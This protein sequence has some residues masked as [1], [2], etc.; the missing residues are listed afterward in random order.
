MELPS[1]FA[2]VRTEAATIWE[3]LESSPVL[4]GPWHRMFQ[5]VRSPRH[6]LSELL[7]NADDSGATCASAKIV[8]DTF[9]FEHN[10]RDF[11]ADEFA[12]LCRF[13]YSNKRALHT[14]GF[15]GVGF[16]STFS[17]GDEVHLST[18]TLSVKFTKSRF[19]EPVWTPEVP[20]RERTTIEVHLTDKGAK[21]ELEM[22]LAEWLASSASLLFFRNVRTLQVN[23]TELQWVDCGD[24]PCP[25]ST[26][27]KLNGTEQ[28]PCLL[29]RSSQ[30]PF[31]AE[32][33]EEIRAERILTEEEALD[34]PPCSVELLLCN[35][36]RLFVVLP[37]GVK[38]NLPFAANAP[39]VQDTARLKVKDPASSPTNRWLLERIG[40]LAADSMLAWLNSPDASSEFLAQAYDLMPKA[41]REESSLEGSCAVA[42]KI[43]FDSVLE[44]R[45]YVL[46]DANRLV[47]G[48]EC[49][50]VPSELMEVWSASELGRILAQDHKAMAS[51]HLS[52]A[53][54]QKLR[55]RQAVVHISRDLVVQQ[56]KQISPT[57]PQS[58]KQ[59]LKLWSYLSEEIPA[60][61]WGNNDLRGLRVVPVQGQQALFAANDVIRLGEKRL[62]ASDDDWVFMSAH[63]RVYNPNW[64]RF[65]AEQ[66]KI[67]ERDGDAE[68]AAEVDRAYRLQNHFKLS[69][70]SDTNQVMR[71]V[72]AD[73]YSSGRETI[74]DCIRLAQIAARLGASVGPEFRFVTK[75]KNVIQAGE[76]VIAD[77]TGRVA[78][79][80]PETWA[81]THILHDSY[82]STWTSCTRQEWLEWIE[83][84]KASL[85]RFPSITVSPKSFWS[86]WEFDA[87]LA[88]RGF[89]STYET[90]YKTQH[91]EFADFD[92]EPELWKHWEQLAVNDE[93]FWA[94][95]LQHIL[96]QGPALWEK[97]LDTKAVQIAKK[98][99]KYPI[100]SAGIVPGW[101]RKLRD[102]PCLRDTRG[103][104]RKPSEVM[105]RTAATEPSV[106]VEPFIPVD[107]DNE[108]NRPLLEALKVRSTPTGPKQILERIRALAETDSPPIEEVEKWYRRLDGLLLNCTSEEVREIRELFDSEP[109]IRSASHGWVRSRE[110]FISAS[111]EDVPDTP[112]I[113]Q[114]VRDLELWRRIHV[115]DRPNAELVL[116]WLRELPV[117]EPLP[118]ESAKRVRSALARLG[119]T[120][121]EQ[122][123]HWLNIS[124]EW[125]PTS[126]IRYSVS[127]RS[128]TKTQEL[129]PSVKQATADFT[130]LDFD[131]LDRYPFADVP[132]LASRL[133]ERVSSKAIQ[134]FVLKK[135]PWL[136]CLAKNLARIEVPSEVEQARLREAALRLA[137]TEW[138]QGA[139]LETVPYLNG[140]PVGAARRVPAVW[141]GTT[142]Y[143]AEASVAKMAAPV[144]REIARGFDHERIGDAV[145]FCF[146][147]DP[148]FILEYLEQEFTL[149]PSPLDSPE[150]PVPEESVPEKPVEAPRGPAEASPGEVTVATDSPTDAN[151][152][153][154]VE[155]PARP[156][157]PKEQDCEEQEGSPPPP[158]GPE[159]N[160]NQRHR[161]RLEK[162]QLIERFAQ[163]K[164][165]RSDGEGRFIG[166]DGTILKR[167][168]DSVFPWEL[169][170]AGSEESQ[171]LMPYEHCLD[172]ESIVL[173]AEVWSLLSSPN[174]K[175]V[176]LLVAPDSSP[177]L[178]TGADLAKDIENRRIELYPAKYRLSPVL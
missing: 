47:A 130:M 105:R 140:V 23:D 79:I 131:S 166:G 115:A 75:N 7:Q 98:G 65:L 64:S 28:S 40:R 15:R 177:I 69:D 54:L 129:F 123:G 32:A 159:P 94:D 137:Q 116:Q 9:V 165:L 125:V 169:R 136:E 20:F 93:G 45:K 163:A 119:V 25:N 154:L 152:H 77:E 147:R 63:L 62:L 78:D 60:Y 14:I 71:Q 57:K 124:N 26:L 148:D 66:R 8:D 146:E 133:D 2:Q 70:S 97:C 100:I 34:M 59:M 110:V 121:W 173:D 102:L 158:A 10:G 153:A 95:L 76:G 164:G 99:S 84:G 17:L 22:N 156:P 18:P 1:Y 24:G 141:S 11:T 21:K 35:D 101:I 108:T 134:S 145:K 167:A 12:S 168:Q 81:D 50:E 138:K 155:R 87:E 46:T 96:D 171:F 104:A 144:S 103:V 114:S 126:E 43:A 172:R 91:F 30:E 176:L 89:T 33:L 5:Q 38:T 55:D 107:V 80:V 83:S 41:N 3:T 53:T 72:A 51:R 142:L 162:P 150:E 139:E 117:G 170:Q 175:Y 68:L 109:L 27:L 174:A 19:T 67:A 132:S 52:D 13:G 85:A 113:L 73:F 74:S 48:G 112:L 149:S 106:D 6:V 143:V 4:A 122:C 82:W 86:K 151:D 111:A 135:K 157:A 36:S 127:M 160:R 178:R 120:A 39:F 128:L 58:W 92:F 31:P 88:S 16:K 90:P 37:T 161:E 118:A 44:N 61:E 42:V 56:L 29:I 49:L